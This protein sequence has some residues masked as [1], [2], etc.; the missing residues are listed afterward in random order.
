[1]VKYFCFLLFS[2]SL[3]SQE[4]S[5]PTQFSQDGSLYKNLNKKVN[6]L[7]DPLAEF[8]E[9]QK[10]IVVDYLGRDNYKIKFKD[11]EGLV[12]I[13][14]LLV[15]EEMIDLYY[16]FQEKE[17]AKLIAS[18]TERKK[19]IYEIV[20]KES[21]E[22][23]EK[24]RQDSIAQVKALEQKQ[25]E[26]QELARKQ[27]AAL[28]EQKRQDSIAHVKAL[29]QK[30]LDAQEQARKQA[31][32]LREQKRQDSIAH[33]KVL[34]QKQLDAQEQARKQAAVLREQK[35]QDS[36][37][38]VKALK[39]KQLE[40]QEQARKQVA[41]LRE[42]KRQD[43]IAHVKALEQK[44]LEAQEQARKQAAAL[45]EQKRQDSIAQV[46]ALKQ[47]QLEAQEQARKRAAALREQKRQDS[48]AHV[49][50]INK[51]Q[52]AIEVRGK[53]MLNEIRDKRIQDS[54]VRASEAEKKQLELA[55][56]DLIEKEKEEK[57]RLERA[58]FRSTCHYVIDEYDDFYKKVYI[59]TELYQLNKNLTVELY[60]YGQKECVFFNLNED[61]GCASYLPRN[62]SS[63]K[64]ILENNLSINFYHSWD[65]DCGN[66]SFKAN[67]SASQIA[68]LKESPIKSI[69]LK[70]TEDS[71]TIIDIE[72]KEFFMDKLKCID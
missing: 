9:N 3:F 29:E 14:D 42:Q 24:K 22:A 59:R 39:Q 16:D 69:R 40:A 64:V 20:N 45:R 56:V 31:A 1:M 35:R 23:I 7:T 12:T 32:A 57:L 62:R 66:F 27:A 18:E 71:T 15:N 41:V 37:A 11:W 51:R 34:E 48:I 4:I 68:K 55:K 17:R 10:C 50:V 58:E 70:G 53:K 19:K 26:A 8:K 13:D 72:Y 65:M 25:L 52:L 63:V 21:L 54:I 47:R 38:Q 36:I 6:Q 44:Q 67:L 2:L 5:I 46:K 43:S 60:K 30:Q 28:R 33:V 61:L 49:K